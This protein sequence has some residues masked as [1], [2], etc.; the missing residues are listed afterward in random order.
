MPGLRQIAIARNAGGWQ[1]AR[2]TDGDLAWT[3]DTVTDRIVV[4]FEAI[5]IPVVA[6]GLPGGTVL[7]GIDID[8]G[9]ILL[10]RDRL[11]HPGD[12]LHEAGHIAVM[13]PSRRA[14]KSGDASKS[15]GDEIAAILWSFAALT[16]LGLPPKVVFH[17]TGYRGASDWHIETFS[18]GTYVG[19]PLL[20]WMGLTLDESNAAERGVPPFPHMLRWLREEP[21]V[22]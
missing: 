11:A 4:F 12:L 3:D 13:I 6:A 1:I 21:E 7:P 14:A 10:D 18:G 9:R 2:M 5:G 19:L 8:R 20:Q 15:M 16:R 17:P 22:A